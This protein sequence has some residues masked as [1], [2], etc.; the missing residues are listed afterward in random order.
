V[1]VTVTA[2]DAA[3]GEM[4]LPEICAEV[5]PVPGVGDSPKLAFQHSDGSSS[6]LK[7][8]RGKYTVVHFWASWCEA[9]KKQLPA[10]RQLQ[11]RYTARGLAT[12]GL[13]LDQDAAAWQT[14]LKR[15]DLP[16]PQGRL[17][18]SADAGVS[19]VPTY[20]LLDPNG[21]IIA[22]TYDLDELAKALAERMK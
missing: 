2:E 12:L 3:R 1:R 18:V 16:W 21:K 20:W 15:I 13:S 6:A 14:V 8:Y 7:D 17:A 22:K 5:A 11:E 9:C 19:S 4:T 10:L